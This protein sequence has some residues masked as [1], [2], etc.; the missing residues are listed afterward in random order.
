[1]SERPTAR[2]VSLRFLYLVSAMDGFYITCLSVL[3]LFIT[4]FAI[5]LVAVKS[6]ISKNIPDAEFVSNF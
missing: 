4:C 1:M 5:T 3:K 2:G 6:L